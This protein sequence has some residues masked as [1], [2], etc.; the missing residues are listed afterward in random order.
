MEAGEW[1]ERR[2]TSPLRRGDGDMS[3]IGAL[4]ENPTIYKELPLEWGSNVLGLGLE[5]EGSSVTRR[6]K[7]RQGKEETT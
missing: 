1:T 7:A 4:V 3:S 2:Y 5:V 6:P